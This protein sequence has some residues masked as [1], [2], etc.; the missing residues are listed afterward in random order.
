MYV[1]C[2][3]GEDAHGGP[4]FRVVPLAEVLG[5]AGP[6]QGLW[7]V[8]DHGV[9]WLSGLLEGPLLDRLGGLGGLR[10]DILLRCEL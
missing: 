7:P 10:L 5:G 4:L 9:A 8:E 3:W 6:L 2:V 1:V